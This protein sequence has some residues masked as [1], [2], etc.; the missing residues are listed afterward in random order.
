MKNRIHSIGIRCATAGLLVCFALCSIQPAYG[1]SSELVGE[2]SKSL[3]ITPKQASGGAGALFNLAKTKLSA[4]DFGQV[5]A[6]V[7]GIDGMMKSAPS[8]KNIPG[9]SALGGAGGLASV[10]G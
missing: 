6:A 1:A 5:A 8:M 2:L 9:M 4:A 3:S 7:P 10:A